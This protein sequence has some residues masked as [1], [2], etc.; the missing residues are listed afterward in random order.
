MA[1]W[2]T[3]VML[4]LALL[5]LLLG[6]IRLVLRQPGYVLAMGFVLVLAIVSANLPLALV[7]ALLL[8]SVLAGLVRN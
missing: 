7:M 3:A 1:V 6:T 8:G 2:V 5:A 4:L